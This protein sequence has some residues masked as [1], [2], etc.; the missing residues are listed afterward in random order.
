MRT[1]Q[2]TSDARHGIL[3]TYLKP[4]GSYSTA[5]K[6]LGCTSTNSQRVWLVP[7]RSPVDKP[8]TPTHAFQYRGIQAC[9][10]VVPLM[11]GVLGAAISVPN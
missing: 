2:S 11:R 7:F 10:R 4:V 8:Y 3:K 9:S 6:V 5:V 1:A